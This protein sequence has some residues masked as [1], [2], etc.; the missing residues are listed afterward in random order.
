MKNALII[1]NP[2]YVGEILSEPS[3]NTIEIED[4]Y[5]EGDY[6]PYLAAEH[7]LSQLDLKIKKDIDEYTL[8][9]GETSVNF[10]WPLFQTE[11]R[12][13]AE[14]T[15]TLSA[16]MFPA[17]KAFIIVKTGLEPHLVTIE[18]CLTTI[19][20]LRMFWIQHVMLMVYCE[21]FR[22]STKAYYVGLTNEAKASFSLENYWNENYNFIGLI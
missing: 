3:L 18:A 21:Q 10:L 13:A 12:L 16:D 8:Q 1:G 17:I 11:I 7:I 2:P 14:Y 15:G 9:W 5:E 4:F 6:Y 20:Y 22:Q 19:A